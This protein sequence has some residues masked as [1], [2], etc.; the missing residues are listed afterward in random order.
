MMESDRWNAADTLNFFST[1]NELSET[2]INYAPKPRNSSMLAK[3][4]A[5]HG[6]SDFY[7]MHYFIEK[8]LGRQEGENAINVYQALDMFLPGL[9]AYQSICNGNIP[10]D[11]PDFRNAA[12]REPFRN[13]HFCT[14]PKI[15]GKELAP[16]CSFGSPSIPDSVYKK[17]SDEWKR[18]EN[19]RQMAE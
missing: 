3:I 14:N 13:N 17:V 8:I 5:G 9:F 1:E 4:T 15:A 11:I 18:K 10:Y 6:G 16:L 12:E 2:Q 7:T 19:E